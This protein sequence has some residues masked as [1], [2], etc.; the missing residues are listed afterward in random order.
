MANTIHIV[1]GDAIV[2]VL[3]KSGIEGDIIVWREMLCEGP[4]CEKVGGD[5][6]WKKRL[7]YF[8]KELDV[9]KLE[10]FDKTIKEL[11]KLEDLSN[12]NEVIMWF[13]FD[14]FCQVNLMAL[15]AFLYQNYRKTITYNLVCTGKVEGSDGLHSLTD[16]SYEDFK[17]LY[18]HKLKLSKTDLEYAKKC[19]GA[20]SKSNIEKIA[21]FNFNENEKFP[22]FQSGIK[23]HLKRFQ[24][25]NGLNE[26]QN[27]ILEIIDSSPLTVKE[28]VQKILIWQHQ[29]TIYGFGDMQYFLYL[30]KLHSFIQISE[31]KYFLNETGK[32]IINQ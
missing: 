6:F 12:Y 9:T 21:A 7:D 14:L 11:L 10:Y 19:W 17:E 3:T 25:I 2:P 4:V 13:E 26:I 8:E 5:E 1:N 22:Y 30:K 18:N 15:S 32:A 28:I 23:Q 31:E 24:N 20:Y 16:F 27:K 29:E